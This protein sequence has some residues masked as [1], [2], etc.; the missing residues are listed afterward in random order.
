MTEQ[1]QYLDNYTQGFAYSFIIVSIFNGVL[2]IIKESTSGIHDV[3]TS[4]FGHHWIGQGVVLLVIFFALGF[5]FSRLGD[6]HD[7]RKITPWVIGATILG[8][9]LIV[10]F[11]VFKII[12]IL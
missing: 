6:Q 5:L 9:G 2:T 4:V 10:L 8:A 12:G 3:L 7:A 1:E 11:Y